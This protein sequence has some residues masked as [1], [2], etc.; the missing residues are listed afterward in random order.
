MN[1]KELTLT[2]AEIGETTLVQLIRRETK[3]L[4]ANSAGTSQ[5]ADLIDDV[6]SEV[7]RRDDRE[8]H[9]MQSK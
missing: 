7:V 3:K 6:L 4:R 1:V 8:G 2:A 5:V 9:T